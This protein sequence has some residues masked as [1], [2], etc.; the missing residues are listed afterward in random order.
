[1]SY[2]LLQQSLAAHQ[3]GDL[4]QAEAGYREIL[5]EQPD[6]IDVLSLLGVLLSSRGA[7][8][9]AIS[10]ALRATQLDPNAALMWVNLGNV[11]MQGND[12]VNATVA[13]SKAT[14]L[15]PD[16]ADAF[17]NMGNALRCL[18]KWDDAK[19]AYEKA[20]AI[21]PAFLL[22]K[23]N[24]AL[25]YEQLEDYPKAI[26]EMKTLLN[27]EPNYAEGWLNLCKIC[28]KSGDYDLG[29]EAGNRAC[30]LMPDNPN[31]WFG[32]GVILNRLQ[33]DEEALT[34]YH[35][36]LSL[37]PDWPEVW[38]NLG[39][40]Y[41]FL[42]RLDESEKAFKATIEAAGQVIPNEE[43]RVVDE[44]EYGN[45]H[46]H[47]ALLQLLKGDLLNGFARYRA[48]FED[49]GGLKRPAYPKPLWKGEDL[50]GKTI[51]V[52][53]EQGVGDCLMLLR[54]LPLMKARGAKVYLL[55]NKFLAPYLQGWDGADLVIPRGEALQEFDYYASIFDLPYVFKTT[56]E[57]IPNN[58]PYLPI[59]PADEK[60]MLDGAK[61]NKKIG[62]I[63]G[64]APKHKQDLKR[65]IPLPIFS[66]LFTN[67]RFQFYSINRDKR[68]G[69]DDLLKALPIIDLAPRLDNFATSGR[70]MS[71][72]DLIITCDTATA[73]QSGGMGKE[74]WTLLPFAPDWRWLIGRDDTPWYPTMRLFRQEKAGDWDSVI[75]RIADSLDRL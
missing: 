69:D 45:H 4:S 55:A 60:T 1:M 33:R 8:Q 73:H 15:A 30:K 14:Q 37:K 12:F 47:L 32:L 19:T 27:V 40:T 75:A 38:D 71:Q 58:V 49:V 36:A 52:T 35:K 51:M 59:L 43:G 34:V 61:G 74:V 16:K 23:N 21:T 3:R 18:G 11:Y 70:F 22:A 2:H 65:S 5:A 54:Y 31:C 26:D 63:W 24:L 48:R 44:K 56:L 6:H 41:Q 64:G 53:D 57:T 39:Q 46:W 72:M 62:V 13:F 25:V 42:N 68:P 50:N 20:L 29:L 10:F 7:Q 9:E 67:D 66:R 17:Y 28:E